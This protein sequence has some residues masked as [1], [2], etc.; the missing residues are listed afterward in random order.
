M[1]WNYDWHLQYGFA[2]D[3]K[4]WFMWLK[5]GRTQPQGPPWYRTFLPSLRWFHLMPCMFYQRHAGTSGMA[6]RGLMVVTRSDGTIASL[7]MDSDSRI[8]KYAYHIQTYTN[9]DGATQRSCFTFCILDAYTCA[10]GW[11]EHAQTIL[12]IN[13]SFSLKHMPSL[14]PPVL[15]PSDIKFICIWNNI[16]KKSKKILEWSFCQYLFLGFQRCTLG[17]VQMHHSGRSKLLQR[18]STCTPR[19]PLDAPWW[20]IWAKWLGARRSIPM[21]WDQLALKCRFQIKEDLLSLES[22]VLDGWSILKRFRANMTTGHLVEIW[23]FRI[24]CASHTPPM[25]T[26]RTPWSCC[27]APVIMCFPCGLT[28]LS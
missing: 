5:T 8:D 18:S 16:P 10:E 14:F 12:A 17:T 9:I 19:K 7:C 4:W 1:T 27:D 23:I 11:L 28:Q 13:S 26:T 2:F 20:K 6:G 21:R 22:W 24:R 3:K 15:V 25:G